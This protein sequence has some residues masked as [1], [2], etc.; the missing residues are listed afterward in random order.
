MC[1]LKAVYAYVCVFGCVHIYI[2]EEK[3][4]NEDEFT[5]IWEDYLSNK[6]ISA[7]FRGSAK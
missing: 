2:H 4:I 3:Y 1:V 5:E 7:L 6:D